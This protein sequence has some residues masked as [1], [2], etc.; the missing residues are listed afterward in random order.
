MTLSSRQ[1]VT[2]VIINYGSRRDTAELSK[3]IESQVRNILVVDNS[4]EING[5]DP[6]FRH[7]EVITP[8]ENLGFGAAA[9][10]AARQ[11]ET[12]WLL[13]LNPDVRLKRNCLKNMLEASS[14]LHAPLCGPR[15]Y[16]DDAC[17]F[18]LP[19]ALGHPLWLLSDRNFHDKNL[20][21]T[22]DLTTL[23]IARHRRFWGEVSPFSE[24]VLS[25]AC[26]L[27][28]NNWFRQNNMPIFDEDF[29]LYYEDTD[30]CGRLMRKGVMPVCVAN[31]YAV[32]YWN[33][34]A[35][36]PAGKA[37][38]M[39]ASERIFLQKYY[40]NGAPPLP[41]RATSPAIAELGSF[42]TSPALILPRATRHLDIGVQ[43]DFIVFAR[44]GITQPAFSFG[45]DMW[46][47]LRPGD[48]Y[49]RAVDDAGNTLQLWHWRKLKQGA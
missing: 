38:L 6:D 23:A 29:F 36:P 14:Q 5:T 31:A 33:Q 48:Y 19:P 45:K 10:L 42:T 20:E 32:H 47:R 3:K 11:I 2:A 30:L 43:D 13:V 41:P 49:F 27:V 44:T 46:Q 7:T 35:E 39:R 18:E 21:D 24:P 8:M 15:F 1:E 16:W 40:P 12:R 17:A 37:D 25:G 28:D 9:N 4:N 22:T 26:L 34:S